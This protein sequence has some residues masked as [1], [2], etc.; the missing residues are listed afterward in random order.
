VGSPVLKFEADMLRCVVK[1]V[2]YF[3]LISVILSRVKSVKVFGMAFA[4]F[5]EV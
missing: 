3:L 4:G 5:E 2:F 1:V